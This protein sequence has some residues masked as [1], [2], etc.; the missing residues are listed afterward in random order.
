MKEEDEGGG[1]R[2]GALLVVFSP[3]STLLELPA[4]TSVESGIGVC[5]ALSTGPGAPPMQ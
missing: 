2:G 4:M 1:R 3:S 5:V